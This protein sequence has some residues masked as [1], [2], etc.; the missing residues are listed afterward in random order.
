MT[1]FIDMLFDSWDVYSR[2]KFDVGKT[3]QKFY[4]KLK[5]KA[6]LIKQRRSKVPLHLKKK[7]KKLLTQPK[8]ADKIREMG[9]E[10]E[11]G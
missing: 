7:L 5:T 3:R 6:E 1:L 2:H 8:N 10:D 11:M 4:V 9:N